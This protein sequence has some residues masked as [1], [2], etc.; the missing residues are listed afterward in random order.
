MACGACSIEDD[1][2]YL[3][4]VGRIDSAIRHRRWMRCV[5]IM[6]SFL[7]AWLIESALNSLENLPFLLSCVSRL[8]N[9][10]DKRL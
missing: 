4:A 3:E 9:L 5:R 10:G 8:H 1:I 2:D 7:S 6:R